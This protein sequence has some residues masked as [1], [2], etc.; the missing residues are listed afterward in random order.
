[1]TTVPKSEERI[2]WAM[3]H[4]VASEGVKKPLH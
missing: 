1:M 2:P 4:E 3:C